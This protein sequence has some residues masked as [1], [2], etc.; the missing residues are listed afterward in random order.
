[1]LETSRGGA[2]VAPASRPTVTVDVVVVAYNSRDT[3]RS[4]VEP[5][6]RLPWASVTVVDNACPE[7][8]SEAVADLSAR[9]V[10]SERNGG[11]AY[12]CNLGAAAG[13]AE[14]VLLLNPDAGLDEGSL[15]ALVDA[16]RADPQLAAVGPRTVGEDGEL[17]FTQRR[18]PRL[19]ST[20]AQALFLHRA[21]PLA[22]W[23]DD[24]VRDLEAY[25]RPGSPE[26]VSGCCVLL[27]RSAFESA[28]GL[29]EGF[30][31]YAEETDLFRRLATA[32]WRVGYEPRAVASHIGQ[33]SVSADTTEHFRAHSRVRYARK[34]HGALVAFLEGLGLALGNVT[35]AA[36]WITRP[37]RAR[38]HL[39]AARAALRATHTVGDTL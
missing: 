27:R 10:E 17:Q 13:S 16:L 8:S 4:C 3:L 29:D 11:F 2:T 34:H 19:R 20:Y 1:V 36:A 33:G 32:G 23:S 15:G 14:F 7:H 31:L 24:A 6:V 12:G 18:F 9:I 30:F 39:D 28:S 35:H 21:A 26:W 38:G 5:L 22:A 37:A 25:E